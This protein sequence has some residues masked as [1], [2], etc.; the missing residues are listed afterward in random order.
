M[1]DS[2]QGNRSTTKPGQDCVQ[3]KLQNLSWNTRLADYLS[4]AAEAL[5]AET[6]LAKI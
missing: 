1:F 2:G 5:G 4:A 3:E 6:V